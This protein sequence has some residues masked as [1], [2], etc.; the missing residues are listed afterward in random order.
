MSA[1]ALPC[2]AKAS[3]MRSVAAG[4]DLGE[5]LVAAARQADEVEVWVGGVG[6]LLEHPRERVGGLERRDDALD[7]R[8]L[9]ERGD[10]LLVGDGLVAGAAGVAQERVLGPA[11][12]VVEAGRDRVRLGD[13]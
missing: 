8:E 11:A 10:G 7:G 1:A 6:F 4:K 2:E 5:V 9:H 13:L 3:A 12:G